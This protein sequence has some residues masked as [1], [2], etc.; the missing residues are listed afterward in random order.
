MNE[1]SFCG[2]LGF[3]AGVA[4][5]MC[6][7]LICDALSHDVRVRE[8]ARVDRDHRVDIPESLT[9]TGFTY[10]LG[11]TGGWVHVTYDVKH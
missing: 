4:L 6:I 8:R 9:C 11:C 2:V 3:L 5:T 10:E 7:L 1:S